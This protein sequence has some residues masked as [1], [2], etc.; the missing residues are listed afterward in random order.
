MLINGFIKWHFRLNF[1]VVTFKFE[2]V[3][4]QQERRKKVCCKTFQ[5]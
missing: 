2:E 5:I 3:N 4:G 1:V